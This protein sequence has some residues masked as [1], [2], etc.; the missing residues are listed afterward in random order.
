MH[1]SSWAVMFS[2]ILMTGVGALFWALATRIYDVDDVGRG[3]ALVFAMML[4]ASVFQLNMTNV[5]VRFLPQTRKQLGLRISQAYAIAAACSFV[6]AIAFAYV[7]PALSVEYAFFRDVAWLPIVFAVATALWAI[8]V[9]EDPVLMALGRATWMP[10]ENFAHSAGKLTL[11][12]LMYV[13]IPDQGL[14][15]AWVLPLVVIVP[16]INYLVAKVAVP[17]ATVAQEGTAG[18]VVDAFGHPRVLVRFMFQDFVGASATQIAIYATPLLTLALLG[19]AA[20][21][22]Y[23]VPFAAMTGLDLLFVAVL[24]SYTA[25]GSR[26]PERIKELTQM[27]VK[28]LVRVQVPASIL[29]WIFAPLLLLPFAS[30]YRE[31]GVEVARIIAIAGIFRATMLFYETVARLQGNGPR[32]LFVQVFH[33]VVLVAGCFLL[34]DPW[35]VNGIAAA[36]LIAAAATA[37]ATGPWLIGFI[38]NPEVRIADELGTRARDEFVDVE[39]KSPSR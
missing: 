11:L 34:A 8:F 2:T 39:S 9:V 12:P 10:A 36:W 30:E 13:L 35:G 1:R 33:M 32:L 24:T 4:L 6:A 7:A 27:V 28:R 19:P 14:F 3:N 17:S 38:R 26:S 23:S 22:V 37:I 25:E 15:L 21:A 31:Q 5:I 29:V 16:V 20:N 18:G